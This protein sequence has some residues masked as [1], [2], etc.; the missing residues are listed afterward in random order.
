[1]SWRYSGSHCGWAPLPPAAGF[2]AGVGLTFHGQ[3]VSGSFA[4]GLGVSSYTFVPTSHFSDHHLNRYAVPHH[5]A[6]Q[7]YHQT[8]PSTTIVG[9]H[10]R[11][12]NHGIPVSHVATASRTQIHT[13][14]IH[15]MNTAGTHGARG[16]RLE[17]NSRTLSVFRPHFPQ[18]AGTQPVSGGHPRSD[19]RQPGGK[20]AAMPAPTATRVAPVQSPRA[21][22]GSPATPPAS[23]G[24]S[25]R[26][27]DRSPNSAIA[28]PRTP[29]GSAP[30]LARRTSD[31]APRP[32]QPL[33]LH[34]PDRSREPANATGTSPLDQAAPPNSLIVK[35][36]SRG[37]RSQTLSQSPAPTP[38]VPQSRPTAPSRNAFSR[39]A[40]TQRTQPFT[41]AEAPTQAP[42]Q[43][44]WSAPRAAEPT[45]RSQRPPQAAA[46]AYTAP[47]E[48]PRSAPAPSYT[49]PRAQS[50]SPPTPAPAPQAAP[51]VSRPAH[52]TPFTPAASGSASQ[53]GSSSGR[54]WR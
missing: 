4:F 12:V 25:G 48:V 22:G 45:V 1:V 50:H 28:A 8:V 11:V 51:A 34:G 39:P 52:S 10:N 2:T 44:R 42:A 54:G 26:R 53:S 33:I 49:P 43:P 47:T 21:S 29:A 30:T 27:P 6:T 23:G 14:G 9:N 18:P 17:A 24:G 16:E 41:I 3:H 19:I 46:P 31:P 40:A 20:P 7:I 5:E 15:D 38:E 36:N 13:I 35:G 32:A 37:T